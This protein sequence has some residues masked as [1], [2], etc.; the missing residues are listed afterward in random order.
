[1]GGQDERDVLRQRALEQQQQLQALEE[2]TTDLQA[3]LAQTVA[4]HNNARDAWTAS[5]THE[6][7]DRVSE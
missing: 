4:D 1:L 7:R 5:L 6:E 2:T 3:R